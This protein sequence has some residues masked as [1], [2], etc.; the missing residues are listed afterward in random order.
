MM[1]IPI[2]EGSLPKSSQ[3]LFSLLLVV[4]RGNLGDG[5]G[6]DLGDELG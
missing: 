2:K 3:F 1:L 4:V 5:L 6:D